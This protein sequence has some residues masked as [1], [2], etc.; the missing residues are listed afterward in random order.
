[1]AYKDDSKQTSGGIGKLGGIVLLIGT[2]LVV[3]QGFSHLT[4]RQANATVNSNAIFAA[5]DSHEPGVLHHAYQQA[6]DATIKAVTNPLNGAGA[7]AIHHVAS[8][9][10]GAKLNDQTAIYS[11]KGDDPKKMVRPVCSATEYY[12]AAP[13]EPEN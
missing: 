5:H 11:G 9:V 2:L 3:T 1:M 10:T 6:K 4:G 12:A 7:A 13:I 8:N